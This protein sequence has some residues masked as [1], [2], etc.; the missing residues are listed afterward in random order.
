M[1]IFLEGDMAIS[2]AQARLGTQQQ[3]SDEEKRRL[4]E[5]EK[6]ID[7]RLA[8]A[9][10]DTPG[11]LGIGLALD[12]CPIGYFTTAMIA[13][14]NARYKALGWREVIFTEHENNYSIQFN[15]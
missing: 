11:T 9:F 4:E 15:P 3:L 10:E 8:K 14:L 5:I 13:N 7:A 12:D 1:A 6:Q 2:P